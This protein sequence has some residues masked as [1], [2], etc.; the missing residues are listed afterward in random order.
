MPTEIREL[1]QGPITVRKSPI[2]GYGVFA[3]QDI[4]ADQL[5]E[6]CHLL[7]RK[8]VLDFSDYVFRYANKNSSVLPLGFGAIY[9]HSSTPNARHYVDPEQDLLL[10]HSN[11][12]IRKDEEIFITYGPNWFS[13]RNLPEKKMSLWRKLFMHCKGMPLRAALVTAFISAAVYLTKHFLG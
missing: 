3:T 9:N 13:A 6:E 12:A 1:Y 11:Q 10:L 7:K 4:A 5:I 8:F 2:H